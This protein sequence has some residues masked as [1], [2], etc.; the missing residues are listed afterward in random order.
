LAFYEIAA[1]VLP[2]LLLAYFVEHNA[3]TSSIARKNRWI[4]TIDPEL[5]QQGKHLIETA[6]PVAALTAASAATGETLALYAV[7]AGSTSA[8]L[9]AGTVA[10][11][12]ISGISILMFAV[13]RIRQP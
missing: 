9:L 7:G 8:F 6:G 12:L 5:A 10:A 11:L 13:T 3:M 2:V 4:A 1:T